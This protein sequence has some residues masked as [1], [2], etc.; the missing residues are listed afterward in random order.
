MK[1]LLRDSR[2]RRLLAANITGS[3]GSGITIFA[4]PW[5]LV[6]QPGGNASFGAVTLVTTIILFFFLPYYGVWVDRHSRKTMMLASELFGFVA[7]A[8]MAGVG[9]MLGGYG[10]MPL[11]IVYFCGMLYYTLHYP[12]KLALLQQLFAKSQYQ[13]LMGLMEIQGQVAMMIAGGLGV[14]LVEHVSLTVILCL[15]AATYLFSF[16][17]QSTIPY[18]ADHLAPPDAPRLSA[19]GSIAEGW[20]WLCDRPRLGVFFTASLLPFIAVMVGNYLFPIYVSQ[21]LASGA[22][23][24]GAGEIIFALGAILAG[25]SLPQLVADHT[26]QRTVPAT[27]AVFA[28]GAAL[29][30]IVPT[31]PVYLFAALLL[32]FGNAGSRVAR[33]AAIL[34]LVDKPVMGRINSF[35][36]AFDRVLRT[37]LTAAAIALVTGSGGQAGF[38]LLLLVVLAGLVAVW[39]SRTALQPAAG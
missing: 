10:L 1:D 29:L 19:W 25:A 24:L 31:V 33:S 32:G 20:Q 26:A 5:L 7:T 30:V 13:S 8:A 16:I 27:M 15:D 6:Q 21:T 38:G 11:S 36:H 18:H 9:A 2:I 22:W 4:V 35:F 34:H 17:I 37:I 23:V 39:Q 12:A 3:I 14:L 28:L